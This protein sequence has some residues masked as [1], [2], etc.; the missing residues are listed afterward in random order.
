MTQMMKKTPP[1]ILK[2]I[3]FDKKKGPGLNS[4]PPHRPNTL[5]DALYVLLE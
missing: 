2:N 5:L 4:D 3:N 1:F